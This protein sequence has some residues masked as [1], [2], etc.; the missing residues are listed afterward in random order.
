LSVIQEN[1]WAL[2]QNKSLK[3][4]MGTWQG[5]ATGSTSRATGSM[6]RATTLE[7]SAKGSQSIEHGHAC[8]GTG[9]AKLLALAI[10]LKLLWLGYFCTESLYFQLQ[11][12]F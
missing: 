9:R 3:R 8:G 1:P 6:G 2:G 5:R 7:K 10:D 12:L 11:I 4:Q